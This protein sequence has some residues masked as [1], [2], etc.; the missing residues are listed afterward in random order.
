MGL[1]SRPWAGSAAPAVAALLSAAWPLLL[2][3][4][5]SAG[6]GGLAKAF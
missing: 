2:E 5:L 4:E 6:G 1:L 3:L